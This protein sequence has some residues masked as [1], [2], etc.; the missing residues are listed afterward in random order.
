MCTI[1]VGPAA[2]CSRKVV[3]WSPSHSHHIAAPKNDD[4]G[5]FAAP[6]SDDEGLLRITLRIMIYECG[7]YKGLPGLVIACRLFAV[8]TS[9]SPMLGQA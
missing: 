5:G 6:T 1:V 8:L 7:V 4:E 3:W 2:L 9:P